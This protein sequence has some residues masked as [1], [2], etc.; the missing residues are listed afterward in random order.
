MLVV[1]IVKYLLLN[2]IYSIEYFQLFKVLC[3][4]SS[5]HTSLLTLFV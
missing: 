1:Q 2:N 4:G 5:C 3:S